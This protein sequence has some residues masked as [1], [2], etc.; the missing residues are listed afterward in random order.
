MIDTRLRTRTQWHSV[1][2]KPPLFLRCWLAKSALRLLWALFLLLWLWLVI[3]RD[4]IM[5]RRQQLTRK[6]HFWLCC[7]P[8]GR[9]TREKKK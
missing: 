1:P 8:S 3:G 6:G 2:A 4:I 7:A 5:N 9:R